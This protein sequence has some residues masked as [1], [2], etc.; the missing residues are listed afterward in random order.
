V[1]ED[2]AV[3]PLTPFSRSRF[4][5]YFWALTVTG[6]ALILAALRLVW[7]SV[8]L[9]QWVS[10][11]ALL[12]LVVFGELRP[13]VTSRSYGAG[14][15]P[16]I[17]FTLAIAYL[18]GPAPAILAQALAS[19]VADVAAR[20]TWWRVVVNPAQYAVTLAVA[21]AAMLPFGYRPGPPHHLHAI[22]AADLAPMAASWVALF[23]I[24]NLL[25]SGVLAAYAGTTLAE[26]FTEDFWY[27]VAANFSVMV[28]SPL[29]ALA[30][31]MSVF[32]IP[33]L[34]PP[35]FAIYRTS[36]MSLEKEYQASHDPLTALP[37][38][39]L[40][41]DRLDEALARASSPQD[42]VGLFILDLDRFKEVNDTLGHQIGDQL[43]RHVADRLR[44]ALRP[45]D[46]VARLGGDEFAVLLPAVPDAETALEVA[47]RIQTALL[48]PFRFEG[49]LLDLEASIGIALYPDHGANA[50]D[51]QRSAD[52]AMYLAK[53]QR[54]GVELY[55]LGRDRHSTS[56]LGLLGAL[57]QAVDCRELEL[58][59]Q[60]KVSLATREV[61]GVEA[62]VRWRHP[63]RGLVFPD[64]F[65]PLAEHSG[66]MYRLTEFVIDTALAQAAQWWR[67]GLPVPVAVNVSARDL[68]S[69]LLA[70]AVATGLARH[71]LPPHAIRLEL[72]ERIL[73]AEP[74]RLD[75]SLRALHSMGVR[76]SLDDFGTGY[77]SLLL[78]Q[79]LPVS[80][81]KI[82]RSFVQRVAQ[83]ADDSSIVRSIVDLAR[84]MGIESVAEGVETEE[85]WRELARLGCHHAQG[86]F[87]A[88]PMPSEAATRWLQE[89]AASYGV[90]PERARSLPPPLPRPAGAA[91]AGPPARGLA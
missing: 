21:Y 23:L 38:R 84:D 49:V 7:V 26:V 81:V 55:S 2:A 20:K 11:I 31:R 67:S 35:M 60:P 65:I 45:Q 48:S 75:A 24:N 4:A 12:A 88:H 76:L 66:L 37:N 18:W 47:T 17:A 58:H 1:S 74:A 53:E 22:Q 73:S 78:L 68:H 61:V 13:V 86:W 3:A 39:K 29:I 82:D 85:A 27:F 15:T 44:A 77:S 36:A 25:V 46:M 89:Y 70:Q 33:L 28:I 80:E 52:V 54:S 57:R 72:T 51:L 43:L 5:L 40:L 59:Y 62:L 14:V 10:L 34:L 16:S 50:Q 41:L 91:V 6:T 64:E 63:Q 19:V 42:H 79:R 69:P 87:V 8:P 90:A 30:A 9:G 32:W 83:S 56:R 71:Q